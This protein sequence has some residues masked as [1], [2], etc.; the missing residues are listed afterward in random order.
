[1]KQCLSCGKDIVSRNVY[2]NNKCHSLTP[3]YKGANKGNG[4][5]SRKK[6]YIGN[7]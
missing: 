1:M 3:T 6:Y 4:R 2:C 5:K 7:E